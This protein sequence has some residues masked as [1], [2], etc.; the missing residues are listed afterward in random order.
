VATTST[1]PTTSPTKPAS[2]TVDEA[3][4]LINS[5][6]PGATSTYTYD[7]HGNRTAATATPTEGT[8]TTTSYA[9]DSA[10]RLTRYTGAAGIVS[11]YTYDGDGLRTN[12]DAARLSWDTSGDLPLLPADGDNWYLY[13]PDGH[14]YT[15]INRTT[16][17]VTYLHADITGSTRATSDETGDRT[18]AWTYAPFG[19]VSTHTGADT[20]PFQYA[21]EYRDATSGL[22]Y[23]RA[24][25]YD[26]VTGTFLTRDPWKP[27]PASPTATRTATPCNTRTPP[28]KSL[29]LHFAWVSTLGSLADLEC[30]HVC[31]RRGTTGPEKPLWAR[32]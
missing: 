10:D 23:L 26:P 13:G 22:Y 30:R 31:R 28:V 24:R 9:Y 18:A 21:G 2:D 17:E 14:P 25:Y 6:S 3:G 8:T 19:S 4:Q 20:T 32:H 29:S 5:T 15:Q 11:D 1:L 16:E 7:T 12:S 27:P